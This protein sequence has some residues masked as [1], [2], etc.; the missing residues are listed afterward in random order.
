[1]I[2][3]NYIL[4]CISFKGKAWKVGGNMKGDGFQNGGLVVVSPK[5]EKILFEFKQ[6]NPADHAENS[7][8]LKVSGR[9]NSSLLVISM[10]F[11]FVKGSDN[12]A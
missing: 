9:Y 11:C 10:L 3:K 4:I 2:A 6:E 7:D 1:M 8:I 5:G 12:N